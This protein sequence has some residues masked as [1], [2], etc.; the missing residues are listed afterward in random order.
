[1][2]SRIFKDQLQGL[3]PIELSIFLYHWK[4]FET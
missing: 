2:D 3:K 1:M 4:A